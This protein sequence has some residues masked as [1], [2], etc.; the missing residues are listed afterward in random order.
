[1]ALSVNPSGRYHWQT[2]HEN[3]RRINSQLVLIERAAVS[4]IEFGLIVFV[5]QSRD[6]DFIFLFHQSI[7]RSGNGLVWR[8]SQSKLVAAGFM[9]ASKHNQRI[10]LLELER[11]HKARGY[12][13]T[14]TFR[15]LCS[16]LYHYPIPVMR[17]NGCVVNS[18]ARSKARNH[19]LAEPAFY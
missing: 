15:Q 2:E 19:R 8:K 17:P 16:K 3:N 13:L 6:E 18:F 9:P 11:G 4:R 12:E 1:M 14:R 5:H 7:G 10:I